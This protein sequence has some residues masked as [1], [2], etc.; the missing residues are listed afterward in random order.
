MPSTI[1]ATVQD[2]FHAHQPQLHQQSH[3]QHYIVNALLICGSHFK[4]RRV[5]TLFE[6]HYLDRKTSY[7]SKSSLHHHEPDIL[8]LSLSTILY[9]PHDR[10]VEKCCAS[11]VPHQAIHLPL[12]AISEICSDPPT[13]C[14]RGVFSRRRRSSWLIRH[15]D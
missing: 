13:R 15:G 4:N 1:T 5:D 12:H 8:F 2:T 6:R 11:R 7:P 10:Q 9:Q 3:Q 14:P